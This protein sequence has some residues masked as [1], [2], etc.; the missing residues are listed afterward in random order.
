MIYTEKSHVSGGEPCLIHDVTESGGRYD[1]FDLYNRPGGYVHIMD[2]NAL[3]QP[4]PQC[5]SR[6]EKIQ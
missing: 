2:K 6:I 4:C 3:K 5:G 1:E